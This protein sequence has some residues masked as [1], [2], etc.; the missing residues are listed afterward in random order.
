MLSSLK[1]YNPGCRVSAG[2]SSYTVTGG[3]YGMHL[4]WF[5]ILL[6]PEM[7]ARLETITK[8]GRF[9]LL[10]LVLTNWL[11]MISRS[12]LRLCPG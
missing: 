8:R 9:S 10:H 4:L 5:L 11:T 7:T 6:G 3:K 1:L 12:F 2:I